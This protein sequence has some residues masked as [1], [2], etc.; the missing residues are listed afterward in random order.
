MPAPYFSQIRSTEE[1]TRSR[2][3]E[4]AGRVFADKGFEKATVREICE[5][6]QVNI[7]SVNYYFGD[8]QRL[9]IEAVKRAHELRTLRAPLPQWP[10]GTPA[11]VKLR[12]FIRTLLTRMIAGEEAPWQH[13]L[14]MQEI[15]QPS[16]ACQEMVEDYIRP[17]FQRLLSILNE[18]LPPNVPL[19]RRH[20]LAFSV[21]G[22]CMFY[23]IGSPVVRLLVSDAEFEEKFTLPR[24]ADHIADVLLSS[25][26][27][28]PAFGERASAPPPEDT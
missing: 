3:L 9:Y 19:D 6:A 1:D 20:Q 7:A 2:L 8:K 21:V 11:E 4:A 18:L 15:V 16:Q 28:G 14:M 13:R 22:Q 5:T 10:E 26:G 23:K 25:L 24:L 17:D 12:D 27:V